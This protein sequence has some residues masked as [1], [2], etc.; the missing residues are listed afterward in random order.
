[1]LAKSTLVLQFFLSQAG[2][3]GAH[4]VHTIYS[5]SSARAPLDCKLLHARTHV[6]LR[7]RINTM[8]DVSLCKVGNQRRV[9]GFSLLDTNQSE[10][11]FSLGA[12]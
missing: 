5:P 12:V 10:V 6:L 7:L 2:D 11:V 1:V 8:T 9:V 3:R 4:I